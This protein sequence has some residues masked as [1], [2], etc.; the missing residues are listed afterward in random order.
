MRYF[1]REGTWY[2][3]P[4]WRESTVTQPLF[5]VALVTRGKNE[6]FFART[7]ITRAFYPSDEHYFFP[8]RQKL[9]LGEAQSSFRAKPNDDCF[10]RDAARLNF[11]K[12]IFNL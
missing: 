11:K 2:H 5:H 12:L 6:G 1:L 10:H 3:G 9:T 7:K 4:E 8:S